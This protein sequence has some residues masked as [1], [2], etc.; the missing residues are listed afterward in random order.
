MPQGLGLLKHLPYRLITQTL[1]GLHCRAG[2]DKGSVARQ[3]NI[4]LIDNPAHGDVTIER[5]PHKTPD[6][7]S[8]DKRRRRRVT[9]P[10]SSRH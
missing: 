3:Q 5:H 7:M 2:G 10:V 4:E 8:K 9:V 6:I 1:P